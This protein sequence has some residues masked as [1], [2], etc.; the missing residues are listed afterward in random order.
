MLKDVQK[1]GY[2]TFAYGT[3]N[4]NNNTETQE[5]MKLE[6]VLVGAGDVFLGTAIK[7]SDLKI[8][9]KII[10]RGFVFPNNIVTFDPIVK[11]GENTTHL[12]QFYNGRVIQM[13]ILYFIMFKSEKW[14]WYC[15]LLGLQGGRYLITSAFQPAMTI[16]GTNR[17][18]FFK[19]MTHIYNSMIK[20]FKY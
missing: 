18:A 4:N 3:S 6:D 10:P 13:N 19:D 15:L 2:W 1:R 9:I 5:L 11:N 14:T 16:T 17:T 7:Q 20:T 8:Y 12:L